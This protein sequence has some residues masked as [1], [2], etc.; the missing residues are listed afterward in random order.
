MDL[1]MASTDCDIDRPRS[2]RLF[3]SRGFCWMVEEVGGWIS[4]VVFSM[5]ASDD[6]GQ[7][8]DET[9]R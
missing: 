7:L 8:V 4:S 5:V 2:D 9:L 6:D 1:T 3:S